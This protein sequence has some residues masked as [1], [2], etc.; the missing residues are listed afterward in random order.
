MCGDDEAVPRRTACR[1]GPGFMSDSAGDGYWSAHVDVSGDGPGEFAP[2]F[3]VD[4][5]LVSAWWSCHEP[6]CSDDPANCLPSGHV[7]CHE[8]GAY[9]VGH[10][11]VW[12]GGRSSPG[13]AG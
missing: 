5:D 11:G 7:G 10:L 9:E 3:D 13:R 4:P 8:T 12:F 6:E 2:R 1:L